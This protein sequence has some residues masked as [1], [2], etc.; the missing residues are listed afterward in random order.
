MYV[1]YTTT[2]V[3]YTIRQSPFENIFFFNGAAQSSEREYKGDDITDGQGRRRQRHNGRPY[4]QSS[5]G[6]VERVVKKLIT[7]LVLNFPAVFSFLFPDF[8]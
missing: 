1:Y 4:Y 8:F 3:V 7:F 2:Y 6:A 5:A